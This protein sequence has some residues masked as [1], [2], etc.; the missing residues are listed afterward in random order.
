MTRMMLGGCLV[1]TIT[2]APGG[3]SLQATPRQT[4]PEK[5]TPSL[6]DR[7]T[8]AGSHLVEPLTAGDIPIAT[9]SELASRAPVVVVGRVLGA[10]SRLAPDGRGIVTEVAIHVHESLRGGASLGSLVYFRV[11]GGSHRFADGRTAKQVVPGF[12]SFRMGATYVLFLRPIRPAV[13]EP[14]AVRA[15]RDSGAYRAQYELASGP[16]GQFELL[17]E[18]G[19]VVP[20]PGGKDHPLVFRYADMAVSDFLVELHRAIGQRHD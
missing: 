5:A 1:A 19:T 6:H 9:L 17:F 18:G 7:A 10:R 13:D 4:G 3:I 15:A 14:A 2:L 20:G 16:Q 11:P 8:A 12:R